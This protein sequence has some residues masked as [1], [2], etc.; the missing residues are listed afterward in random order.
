MCSVILTDIFQTVLE[1][2]ECFLSN[3]NNNMHILATGTEEQAV[4]SGHLWAPFIQATQYC[5]CSHKK[6]CYR[7]KYQQLS[8]RI[9]NSQAK[10]KIMYIWISREL[11]LSSCACSSFVTNVILLWLCICQWMLVG[12]AIGGRPHCNG[13]NGIIGTE[14]NMWFPYVWCVWYR[15]TDSSYNS[16]HQPPLVLVHLLLP[17]CCWW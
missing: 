13:K 14:S 5:P 2:S 16:S 15:C 9:N 17:G 1:T 7:S 11:S 3:A 12:V 4:Y 6:S 10:W 8:Q